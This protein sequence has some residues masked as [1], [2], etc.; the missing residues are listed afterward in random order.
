MIRL[1]E[2]GG[3][4]LFSKN[5]ENELWDKKI[6][7]AVRIQDLPTIETKGLI[8]DTFLKEMIR[9]ILIASDKKLKE[10]KSNSTIGTSSFRREF[11][12]KNIRKDV[13]ENG[14]NVDTRIKIKWWFIWYYHFVLCRNWIFKIK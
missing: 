2:I 9:E 12:I 14:K 1:S 10:L 13:N 11:Q 8:T 6:D 4:G 5:I 7:I 3:K